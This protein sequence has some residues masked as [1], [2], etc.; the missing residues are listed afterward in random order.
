M[1]DDLG[2]EYFQGDL[3]ILSEGTVIFIHQLLF[4]ID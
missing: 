1:K 4:V 2:K 3:P